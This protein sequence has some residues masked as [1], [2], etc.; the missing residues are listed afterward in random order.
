MSV[1]SSGIPHPDLASRDNSGYPRDLLHA[2]PCRYLHGA[3]TRLELPGRVLLLLHLALYHRAGRLYSRYTD[4]SNIVYYGHLTLFS[5]AFTS[6]FY[7]KLISG[8]I[9]IQAGKSKIQCPLGSFSEHSQAT[10]NAWFF[11]SF[12]LGRLLGR[13]GLACSS[14]RPVDSKVILIL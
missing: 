4:T 3:G 12:L 14:T 11:C 9:E 2:H 10:L 1:V 13:G 7:N 6:L 8:F 5:F